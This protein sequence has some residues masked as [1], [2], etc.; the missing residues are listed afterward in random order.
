MTPS[1]AVQFG[2]AIGDM[3]SNVTVQSAIRT[4]SP[5]R[6]A[7]SSSLLKALSDAIAARLTATPRSPITKPTGTRGVRPIVCF[8]RAPNPAYRPP[9][10]GVG[11]NTG[12]NSDTNGERRETGEKTQ[13]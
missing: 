4:L 9:Q 2:P 11:T 3:L 6:A 10:A 5:G 7:I 1:S 8:Q 12:T 13:R